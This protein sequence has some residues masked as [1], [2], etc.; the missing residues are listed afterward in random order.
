MNFEFKHNKENFGISIDKEKNLYSYSIKGQ[1]H[2]LSAEFINPNCMIL[3]NEQN[4]E[5]VY[6]AGEDEKIFI[7]YKGRQ[8]FIENIDDSNDSAIQQSSDSA[9]DINSE[10]C[11]PMPG[12]ILKI[13]VKKGEKV[14]AKQNLIIIEAMKMEHNIQAPQDGNVKKIFFKEGDIVDTGQELIDLDTEAA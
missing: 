6:I 1:N 11:S 13:L 2:K 3:S 8:Y 5:R 7:H 12:K 4:N 9:H 10:I 14:K